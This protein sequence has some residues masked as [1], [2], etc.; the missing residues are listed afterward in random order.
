MFRMNRGSGRL[1]FVFSG[2]SRFT[3]VALV[4]A[5]VF[6][7]LSPGLRAQSPQPA[8]PPTPP[9]Q[10]PDSASPDSG[11]PGGDNGP[12]V[13]PKKKVTTD[14]A[15]TPPP[16]APVAPKIKNPENMPTVSLHVDVPEVT[17]DVG[18]LLEKTHQFVPNLKA[19]NFRIFE[20]GKEQKVIGFKRTE[21]PITALL[22]CEFAATLL[23]SS[24]VRRTTLR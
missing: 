9:A 22:V 19:T 7:S 3:F 18:V 4:A 12:I 14:D 1:D 5:F 11:G 10:Q 15:D 2:G 21:A 20:D 16:A 23:R 17:V 6:L 8:Q 13:V 24:F